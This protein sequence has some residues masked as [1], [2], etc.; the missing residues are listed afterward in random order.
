[1]PGMVLLILL[2][3]VVLFGLIFWLP[4]ERGSPFRISTWKVLKARG[5]KNLLNR[6]NFL[7]RP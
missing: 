7:F 1:M 3:S 2:G 4:G 6:K 5:L